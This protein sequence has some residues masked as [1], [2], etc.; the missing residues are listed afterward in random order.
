MKAKHLILTIALAATARAEDLYDS[1]EGP[2]LK[3]QQLRAPFRIATAESTCSCTT[4]YITY[5]GEGFLYTADVSSVTENFDP[6]PTHEYPLAVEPFLS[7]NC[8]PPFT[9]TVTETKYIT[10]MPDPAPSGPA[11]P[12]LEP[13]D[14]D[15]APSG[16]AS[17]I[18]EP[19]DID[20]GPSSPFNPST[21]ILDHPNTDTG[22]PA[23]LPPVVPNIEES[24]S[25]PNPSPEIPSKPHTGSLGSDN[26]LWAITFSPFNDDGKCKSETAVWE[27][28]RLIR[29]AG[30]KAIRVYGTECSGIEHISSAASFHGLKLIIGIFISETG[31]SGAE[32]QVNHIIKWAKWEIVELIVIGNEALFNGHTSPDELARFIN[33]TRTTLRSSGYNGPCTTAEPLNIWQQSSNL[34]CGAVDLVG[35]NIHPFF[36]PE[37]D[38]S[39]AG[40]FVKD[41]LEIVNK[42]CPGKYGIN[43]ECG[44]PSAGECNGKACPGESEQ[45]IAVES[46]QSFA[47]NV[48][49]MFTYTNDKWKS[50]GAFKV[51]QSF[52]LIKLLTSH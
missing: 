19:P 36:N 21:P 37:V 30:F 13:P 6:Q 51:E 1:S 43:L 5:T 15:P 20:V 11:S 44:W 38:A 49:V 12:I 4:E 9:I 2:R 18:L 32:E 42:I 29:T 46:I 48:S 27:D 17:P 3:D 23:P 41:Q 50:P 28:V 16:P 25:A 45:K 40:P 34:L 22:P 10:L 7:T 39:H 24:P 8:Q 52:G 35:C 14:I 31:C 26:G 47:G 33:S